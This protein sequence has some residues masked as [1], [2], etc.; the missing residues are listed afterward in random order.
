[1]SSG[2]SRTFRLFALYWLPVV[3]YIMLVLYFSS[4]SRLPGGLMLGPFD[5]T[6][7]FAQYFVLGLLIARASRAS[8]PGSGG[9][10][11]WLLG[12]ALGM[13]IGAGDE[14]LQATV[15]GRFCSMTDFLADTGGIVLSQCVVWLARARGRRKRE[16]PVEGG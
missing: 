9:L 12:I 2:P 5:K 13:A 1:M 7:H 11:P 14:R 8:L 16:A 4:R 10:R 6:A 15:P 3:A